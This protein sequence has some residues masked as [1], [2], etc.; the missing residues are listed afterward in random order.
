MGKFARFRQRA[1]MNLTASEAVLFVSSN[2]SDEKTK[3]DW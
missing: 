1:H 2:D 3:R